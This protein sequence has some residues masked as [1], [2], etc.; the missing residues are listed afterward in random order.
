MSLMSKVAQALRL[1]LSCKHLLFKII[2]HFQAPNLYYYSI[3]FLV[4]FLPLVMAF[5]WLN[6]RIAKEIW[7]RRRPFESTS[8]T[9][10][11]PLGT[12]T[13]NSCKLPESIAGVENLGFENEDNSEEK[14]TSET[15][16]ASNEIYGRP[17]GNDGKYMSI[18]IVI[19]TTMVII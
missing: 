8:S 9:S 17:V 7:R 14:R 3:V 19:L 1:V 18:F 4:I 2:L 13:C 6:A 16:T 15:N 5:V 12:S 11:A 10:I